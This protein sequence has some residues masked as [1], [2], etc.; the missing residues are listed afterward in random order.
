MMI[1]HHESGP[2]R[3]DWKKGRRVTSAQFDHEAE[4]RGS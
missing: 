4:P 2:R 1:L 3:S